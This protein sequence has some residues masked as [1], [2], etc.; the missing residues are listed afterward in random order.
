MMTLG[1]EDNL[2]DKVQVVVNRAGAAAAE[3]DISLK[4]AEETIGRPIFW[5]IPNDP[6]AV[7]GSRVTGTPLIQHA[8]TSRAQQAYVGLVNVMLGRATA[9]AAQ[10]VQGGFKWTDLFAKKRKV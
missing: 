1:N 8:P 7:M 4:K 5:Q 9:P 10:S 3:G 2:I 6:K